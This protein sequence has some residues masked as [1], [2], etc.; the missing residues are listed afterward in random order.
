[1][2]S[3]ALSPLGAIIDRLKQNV[4]DLRAVL[5]APDLA[6]VTEAQQTAPSAHVLYGGYRLAGG[7][8]SRAGQGKAQAI[9]QTWIVVLAV[10]HAGEQLRKRSSLDAAGELFMAVFAALAG[11]QPIQSAKPMRLAGP[12]M[13][14]VYSAA[15]CYIPLAFE[16]ELVLTKE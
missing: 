3:N 6:T 11:W 2:I 9:V 4:T 1:M 15:F 5:S 14:P 8:P 13:Q 10:K 7:E 12:P 16:V